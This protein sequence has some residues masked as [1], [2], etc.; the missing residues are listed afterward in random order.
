[1]EPDD[2]RAPEDGT[3]EP[4]K[5]T[6]GVRIIGADEA[7]AALD[8][9]QAE[10]RRPEDAPRFGDLPEQPPPAGPAPAARFPLPDAVDPAEV[11]LPPLAGSGTEL[12]HWTEP[13]TGEVPAVVSGAGASTEG[14]DMDA[15]SGFARGGARWR[16]HPRDWDDAGFDDDADFGVTEAAPV[17]G[18]E[19]EDASFLLDASPPTWTTETRI[20]EPPR[21]AVPSGEVGEAARSGTRRNLAGAGS[22]IATGVAVGVIA[23]LMLKAGPPAALVLTTL[24]ATAAAA[25]VFAVLRRAGYRPAVLLGLVATVSVMV[26]G[27]LKGETALPLVVA[28]TTMFS[29][30]WYLTGV[31]RARALRNVAA[32]LAGFLWV[33][34]LGSYAGLLLQPG[35]FPNRH[36]E[37]FLLGAL[38]AAVSY[39]VA[40]FAVGSRLGR[41]PL[42]PEVSPNKTWEGLIAGMLASLL[43]SSLVVSQIHP[44]TFHKAVA[45]GLVAAVAAPIGDLCQSLVKRDL[46][47]KDMGTILPGH[48]GVL[49][50][51][52]AILFVL[53]AT[54][55]LV[56][57]LGLG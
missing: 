52:D 37:A 46:G 29:F 38:I 44:W 2:P 56:R 36:G 15:W 20:P 43:L 12:P 30:L 42:A 18:E 6:E 3:Q 26:G 54:Y 19:F 49:D 14:D 57:V 51:V 25:E 13:P 11:R 9:G 48:G 39:D 55:Y 41:H 24:V 28:L 53:P 50:R 4:R 47:I 32:T 23:L 8:S 22:R 1:M 33:G 31:V 45:L 27:Y 21:Y 7:A 40:G 5:R 35:A 16:D 34:F 17:E 10:G